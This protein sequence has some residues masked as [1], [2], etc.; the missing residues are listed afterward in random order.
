VLKS[1]PP[2]KLKAPMIVY[3]GRGAEQ[4]KVVAKALVK[5]GQQNVMVLNGGMIGWQAAGYAVESGVP[6]PNQGVLHAQAA[7]RFDPDGR[8]HHAGQEH[9]RRRADPGRAQPR[10]SRQGMIKGAC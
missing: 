1:L 9:A 10:R 5:A 6:A 4:A 7:C 8:V 3:D 2:A